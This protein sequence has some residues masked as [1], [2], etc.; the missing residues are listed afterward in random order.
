MLGK[1][2]CKSV[3]TDMGPVFRVLRKFN[4]AQRFIIYE[5]NCTTSNKIDPYNMYVGDR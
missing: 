3:Q 1:P 5:E 4:F 2:S